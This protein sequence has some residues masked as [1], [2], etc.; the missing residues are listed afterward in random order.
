MN[1]NIEK[2]I[3]SYGGDWVALD[4]NLEKVV[5]SAK[6]AKDAL[7][8]AEKKGVKVPHLFKVPTRLIANI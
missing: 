2:L 7:N 4:E 5:A 3:K 6:H 8:K 1:I